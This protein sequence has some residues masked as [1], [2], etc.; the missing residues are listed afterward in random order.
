[1]VAI[2]FFIFMAIL[3]KFSENKFY[4]VYFLILGSATLLGYQASMITVAI[5]M[6]L[7]KVLNDIFYAARR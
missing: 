4:P 3:I 1:M 5:W 7:G 2:S 6:G